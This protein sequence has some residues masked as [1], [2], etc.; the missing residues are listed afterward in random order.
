MS[1][2][3]RIAF[4][5][6]GRFSDDL[7]VF[8]PDLIDT[9]KKAGMKTS[10]KEYISAGVLTSSIFFLAEIP[11]LSFIFG[12]FFQG[13]ILSLITAITISGL[14]TVVVFFLFTKYP[15]TIVADRSKKID[16]FLPF[17]S[18]FLSTIAGTKLPLNQVFKMF[19][20]NSK[21]GEVTQQIKMMNNDMKVFGLDAHTALQRAIDRTPSKK[22]KEM[23]YG[24]LS[25]SISGGDVA[26]YLRE[27]AQ[28]QMEDYRRA[29]AQFSKKIA[30][31]IELYLTA[32]VLGA[33]FFVVLTSIF[34]GISGVGGN[35]I[36]LQSIVIFV[37][38]PL[39]STIFI[40]LVKISSPTGE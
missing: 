7:A 9:L 8:F 6:F 21:Y 10:N 3:T 20:E 25:T 19:A 36:L 13:V 18:L 17:A 1:L 16:T 14:L 4:M 30:I 24:L 29:I 31:F 33:I 23:L 2:Y 11:L 22:M 37:F 27:K 28:T 5:L 40:L 34:S 32:I 38:L 35:I 12:I 39:L 15:N 26:I